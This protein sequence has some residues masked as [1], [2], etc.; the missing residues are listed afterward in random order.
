MILSRRWLRLHVEPRRG[1]IESTDL[2]IHGS[3]ILLVAAD[4]VTQRRGFCQNTAAVTPRVRLGAE[5][6]CSFLNVI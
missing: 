2:R 3:G 4:L 1:L 6:Q 5:A